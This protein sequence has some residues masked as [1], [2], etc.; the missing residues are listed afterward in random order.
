MHHFIQ[1][2]TAAMTATL[3]VSGTSAATPTAPAA[4]CAWDHR[5]FQ[6]L[7]NGDYTLS[8][9]PLAASDD[10]SNGGYLGYLTIHHPL[11]GQVYNFDLF[12]GSGYGTI[13]LMGH[14]DGATGTA[15]AK[16]A[17]PKAKKQTDHVGTSAP[18]ELYEFDESLRMASGES[19][20]YIFIPHLGQVDYYSDRRALGEVPISPR[21]SKFRLNDNLWKIVGCR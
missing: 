7:G 3:L 16:K 17:K 11:R 4:A 13:K 9:A 18:L 1:T 10:R 19:T 21:D 12:Q 6:N 14:E 5:Q 15:H 8:F 2:L 20:K